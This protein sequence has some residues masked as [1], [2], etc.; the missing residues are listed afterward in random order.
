MKS[1]I[2]VC[3]VLAMMCAAAIGLIGCGGDDSSSADQQKESVEQSTEQSAENPNAVKI[4]KAKTQ[5]DYLGKSRVVV[6]IEWTNN[7]DETA[8]FMTSYSLKAY[9][10]GEEIN[11][12]FGDGDSWYNDQKSIKPGKTQSFKVMFESTGKKDVDVEIT[13]LFGSDVIASKTFELK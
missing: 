11:R 1:K 3:T 10:D 2:I 12:T 6:S 7:G 9:Q 4:G 13:E 8:D 5:K